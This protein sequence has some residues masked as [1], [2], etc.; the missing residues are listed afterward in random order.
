MT[1]RWR[2]IDG[3]ELYDIIADPGQEKDVAADHPDVVKRLR[4]DYETWWT[5]LEPALRQTVRYGLGGAENPTTLA[6]H[7]WLMPGTQQAAWHQSHIKEGSL[8]NGAWA[9]DVERP[10]HAQPLLLR[11]AA[12]ISRGATCGHGRRNRHRP[13]RAT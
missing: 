3:K 13:I 10:I 7:D 11:G 12:I 5:S 8:I 4:G 9:V 2:L 1:Q 6:S